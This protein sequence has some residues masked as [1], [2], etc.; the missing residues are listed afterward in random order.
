MYARTLICV[1]CIF[2]RFVCRMCWDVV[3][4]LC[5]FSTNGLVLTLESANQFILVN[6]LP[7]GLEGTSDHQLQIRTNFPVSTRQKSMG[8]WIMA[9]FML[10]RLMTYDLCSVCMPVGGI[11]WN[12]ILFS[13]FSVFTSSYIYY[14]ILLCSIYVSLLRFARVI[15]YFVAS[16]FIYWT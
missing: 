5:V 10:F 14:S 11:H 1:E 15:C 7:E 3:L 8:L 9:F 2:F 6:D 13:I 4:I 12:Q 16:Y